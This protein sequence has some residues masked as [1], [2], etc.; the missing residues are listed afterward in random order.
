MFKNDTNYGDEVN[1]EYNVID[2][3]KNASDNTDIHNNE[4]A[5]TNNT[6]S[7]N[8]GLAT[9]TEDVVM[10]ANSHAFSADIEG[11]EKMIKNI[12]KFLFINRIEWRGIVKI[13]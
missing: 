12:F 9:I 7:Y 6:N 4:E 1:N 11:S 5:T 13:N 3:A 10:N 2:V 8:Q